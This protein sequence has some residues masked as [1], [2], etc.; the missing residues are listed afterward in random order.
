[1]RYVTGVDEHGKPMDV[2]DPTAPNLAAAAQA[3]G[4]ARP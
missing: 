4:A 1:M 3:A 2:Q